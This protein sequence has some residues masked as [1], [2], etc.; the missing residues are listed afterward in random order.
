MKK[1]IENAKAQMEQFGI[2][3]MTYYYDRSYQRLEELT[4]TSIEKAIEKIEEVL[5]NSRC[6][7]LHVP[8]PCYF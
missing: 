3:R 1:F 5:L 2:I 4:F 7:D 6:D 8:H